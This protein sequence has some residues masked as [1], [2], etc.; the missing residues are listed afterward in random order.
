MHEH[1]KM[2]SRGVKGIETERRDMTSDAAGNVECL[3]PHS[4]SDGRAV[5]SRKAGVR[6]Y[7]SVRPSRALS[8]CGVV[9]LSDSGLR[10]TTLPGIT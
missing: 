5:C 10:L 6:A 9:R 7:G 3:T 2:N 4:S 1:S 8:H